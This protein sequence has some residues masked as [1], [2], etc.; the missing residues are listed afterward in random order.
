MMDHDAI[1]E[2]SGAYA[3]DA[4]TVDEA[5]TVEDHIAGCP[6]CAAIV[7]DMRG[8]VRVLPL[9][10]ESVEP[11]PSLKRR[12]LDLAGGE[13]KA[14]TRLRRNAQSAGDDLPRSLRQEKSSWSRYWGA[15][16]AAL[17]L[18]AAGFG[19]GTM[20]ARSAAAGHMA[21]MQAQ[22]A[23]A[24]EQLAFARAAY[25]EIA[26]DA[27]NVHGV[28]ADVA[29]GK[30]WDM[31]GGTG[32]RRW[33]CMFVQPPNK[34]NATL[35]ANIPSAPH[36]MKYQVWIIRKGTFHRAPVLPTGVAML[37]MPMPLE[38]GD[39]VA[40]SME[41]PQGSAHPTSGFMMKKTLL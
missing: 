4:V 35:I 15:A 18:I 11:S 33:H 8:T 36:G 20:Q 13:L 34:K 7:A 37:E 22:A 3:L 12:I 10:C 23:K 17:L 40:F 16:A 39:V 27:K 26:A 29:H 5:R 24:Q 31:S 2:L 9:S 21:E 28:V 1:A 25:A 41:P 6:A 32:S 38:A 30:V 19:V 14:E